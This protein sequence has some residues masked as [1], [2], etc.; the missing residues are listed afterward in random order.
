[1]DNAR[2]LGGLCSLQIP[3]Y[4]LV[5]TANTWQLRGQVGTE[6]CSPAVTR[7]KLH[8]PAVPI[9]VPPGVFSLQGASWHPGE[10]VEAFKAVQVDGCTP[11]GVAGPG[12][13]A[14]C[15]R[16]PFCCSTGNRRNR[17]I[18]RFGIAHPPLT[19]SLSK[20][21]SHPTR[22]NK[23][24]QEEGLQAGWPFLCPLPGS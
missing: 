7:T 3:N 23:P 1:M 18:R 9:S 4:L 20:P 12:T 14:A 11:L 15:L 21:P 13:L 2:I 22:K 8:G 6:T 24:N 5:T 16:P 17:T 19:F 10:V